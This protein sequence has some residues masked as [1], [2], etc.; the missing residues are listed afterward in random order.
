MTTATDVHVHA[1]GPWEKAMLMVVPIY[2]R[3][4]ACG[5]WEIKFPT[6]D[7]ISQP[8]M[9]LRFAESQIHIERLRESR[10]K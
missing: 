2:K 5:E 1:F 4:C 8:E 9:D 10:G 6:E 3:D 7:E